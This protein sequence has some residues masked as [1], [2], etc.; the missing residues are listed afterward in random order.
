VWARAALPALRQNKV[1]HAAAALD[2]DQAARK[3]RF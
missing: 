2:V 3:A 1:L